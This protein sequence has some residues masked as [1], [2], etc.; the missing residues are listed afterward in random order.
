M[1]AASKK[2][3]GPSG[4][5]GDS[6]K[7]GDTAT[8]SSLPA[9]PTAGAGGA[10]DAINRISVLIDGVFEKCGGKG[11]VAYAW[12][13]LPLKFELL[14]FFMAA[15]VRYY[16]ILYPDGVV[17]DEVSDCM[18]LLVLATAAVAQMK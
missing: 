11:P 1:F 8:V 10:A 15:A 6:H 4:A 2:V 13:R 18:Y 17:F 16:G 12:S 7:T 3:R 9:S 5:G 14:L